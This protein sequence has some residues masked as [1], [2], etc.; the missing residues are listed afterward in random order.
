[1]GFY[2]FLIVEGLVWEFNPGLNE[3][4]TFFVLKKKPAPAFNKRGSN[5]H[6]FKNIYSDSIRRAMH[7]R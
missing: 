4:K 5:F 1:M 6:I 3:R 7:L 2:D